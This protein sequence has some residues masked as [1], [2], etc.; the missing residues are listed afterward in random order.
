M[1]GFYCQQWMFVQVVCVY[2][3]V[4]M[5]LYVGVV[6]VWVGDYGENYV[7]GQFDVVV[8]VVWYYDV[9]GCFDV[10]VVVMF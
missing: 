8:F 7:K 5:V 2:Y 9:D 1:V 4:Y 6:Y 10:Q 3:V